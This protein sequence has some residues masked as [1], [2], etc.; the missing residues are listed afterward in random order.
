MKYDYDIIVIG[1][2]SGGL[3]VA[4]GASSL[5]ARVALIEESDMGGDCLNTGC[6]PSKS[7]LKVGHTC[8][9]I[10]N[11]EKYGVK[12]EIKEVDINKVM[13]RGNSVIETIRPKDSKGR[14]EK[15]GVDVIKGRGI[16][17]DSNSIK[18]GEKILKTKNIVIATGSSPFI[19]DIKGLDSISYFTNE[20]IFKIDKK[21][22]HL[23]VLGGGPIGL[24]LGQGFSEIG[25]KVTIID[26]NKNM[27]SKDEPEVGNLMIDVF[28]NMDISI[29]LNSKILEIEKDNEDIKV[30]IEVDGKKEVVVGDSILVSLGRNPNTK[31][32]GAEKIGLKL[33]KRGSI[34]TD[35]Q[36]KTNI[37]NIY[38]CGDV[39][40]PYQFT[41]M[42]SYQASI[43]IKSIISPIKSKADYSYVPWTTYTKPEVSHVGMME[44]A[45]KEKRVFAKSIT[46][47]L[48]EADKSVAEG[49]INGFLKLILGKGGRVLGAT[50]VGEKAGE[51]I[52]IASI[53]IKNKMKV[54]DFAHII[55]PYPS[56]SEIFKYAALKNMKD[57]FKPWQKKLIKKI[58]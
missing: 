37:K 16:I 34:I 36:M 46:I 1:G 11:S 23:I 52:T 10:R 30:L 25:S 22:K 54:N 38:A 39:T 6:V 18:V 27:F 4:S 3:V 57:N 32:I 13:K 33:D 19:P 47:P 28:R 45:A 42:A 51:L 55:Y 21:P 7:F 43:V 24:E 49:D 26:R 9:A 20:N 29:K 56:Q 8:E 17:E 50:I 41:H 48:D 14:Y 2:G 15:M 35:L 58:M 53:A 40:G 44:K 31:N 12:S 5:G